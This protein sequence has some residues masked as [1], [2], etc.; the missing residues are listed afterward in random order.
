MD[1]ARADGSSPSAS[2]TNVTANLANMASECGNM[3]SVFAKPDENLLIAGIALDGL[4]ASNNGGAN[5]QAMGTGSGSAT[6]TNRPTSIA[7]DPMTSTRFWESGIYNGGGVYETMDDGTTFVQ[8]GDVT[9]C[10]LVSIDFSDPDRQ[11]MLAGGHEQSQTLYRSADGG[12]TW[13][14][15]GAGLPV[16]TNCTFPMII[17]SQTHLVGCGGYGGGATGIYRT[18]DG[19]VT[20]VSTTASGGA[21]APLRATDQSIYWASPGGLGMTR[22][23]DDGQNWADVIGSGVI[24]AVTPIELPDG[25]IAT[26]G[27]TYVMVSANHGATW[28]P[29]TAALPYSDAVGIVYSA[30]EK[31]FYTWHF[32]CGFNG[33]VPV[34][35]DAIMKFDFDYQ[36]N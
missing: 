2:W 4:W 13:N 11:T 7:Y 25:R 36:T 1:G 12:T 17:D 16:N 15:V 10:D 26:L 29:A 28:S 6:I 18:T 3:T 14:N 30:Q 21:S 5:W 9:H 22:S 35:S 33:P 19:G 8:V 24:T 23:T 31:A 20:W 32:T 27:P 34:P